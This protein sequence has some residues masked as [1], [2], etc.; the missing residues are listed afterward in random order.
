MSAATFIVHGSMVSCFP[1]R[2]AMQVEPLYLNW[3]W[4]NIC[5]KNL[6]KRAQMSVWCLC[7]SFE[8]LLED[9]WV[10]TAW[11]LGFGVK[12][13]KLLTQLFL[14]RSWKYRQKRG[15]AKS[16]TCI[17]SFLLLTFK[18]QFCLKG[19]LSNDWISNKQRKCSSASWLL[20]T[21]LQ[22]INQQSRNS[23]EI[24]GEITESFVA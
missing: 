20:M 11:T 14:D 17:F 1:L 15:E 10:T 12:V 6:V 13:Y 2:S 21:L 9:Y 5:T 23:E 7:F 19:P 22:E 3:I 8:S 16:W 24:S 4:F 18:T